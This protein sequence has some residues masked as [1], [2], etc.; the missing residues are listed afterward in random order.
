MKEETST[1]IEQMVSTALDMIKT[2][3]SRCQLTELEALCISA[4]LHS[5]LFSTNKSWVPD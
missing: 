1:I 4:A 5:V 2:E 3:Q